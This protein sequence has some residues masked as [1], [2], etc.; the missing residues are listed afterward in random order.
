MCF[1]GILYKQHKVGQSCV[2]TNNATPKKSTQN[3]NFT[4]QTLMRNQTV[5]DLL[6]H[7]CKV[8]ALPECAESRFTG[9]DSILPQGGRTEHETVREIKSQTLR[10][11]CGNMTALLSIDFGLVHM[12]YRVI[13]CFLFIDLLHLV[14]N[15]LK[16]PVISSE[17][18]LT[19]FYCFISIKFV[20]MSLW[21]LIR[22][23]SP[24]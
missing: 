17:S 9:L 4:Q 15:S 24:I 10:S 3:T 8:T 16:N 23:S 5:C 1:Y 11:S 19:F 7:D 20:M 2:N 14:I 6:G 21:T 13:H 12:Q 22:S 18:Y